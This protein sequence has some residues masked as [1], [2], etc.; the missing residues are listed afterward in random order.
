[1]QDSGSSA[2]EAEGADARSL[3]PAFGWL[4]GRPTGFNFDALLPPVPEAGDTIPDLDQ[5]LSE[6]DQFER[7]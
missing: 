2:A 5:W 4:L 6:F 7:Q 3:E 1:M